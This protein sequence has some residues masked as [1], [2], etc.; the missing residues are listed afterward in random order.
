MGAFNKPREIRPI[1]NKTTIHLSQRRRGRGETAALYLSS[2][3]PTTLR[4]TAVFCLVDS[5]HPI[6]TNLRIMSHPRVNTVP[7]PRRI[8][9]TFALPPLP[10]L[11]TANDFESRGQAKPAE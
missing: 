9:T 2:A 11:L 5:R 4:E 3:P 7:T 10:N 1:V 6:A 8:P